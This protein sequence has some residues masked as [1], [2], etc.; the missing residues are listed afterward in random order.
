MLPA[1]IRARSLLAV[2][3]K[4]LLSDEQV[5]KVMARLGKAVP[6][7]IGQVAVS[8]VT[9]RKAIGADGAIEDEATWQAS[10]ADGIY[11]ILGRLLAQIRAARLEKAKIMTNR[12]AEAAL[13]RL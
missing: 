7:F 10:G 3:S 2:T 5:A 6:E 12:I 9:A 8:A 4:D 11:A 13:V 1:R